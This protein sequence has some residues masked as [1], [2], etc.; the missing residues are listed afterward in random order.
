MQRTMCRVNYCN[1]SLALKAFSVM[2]LVMALAGIAC[3]VTPDPD[4][5]GNNPDKYTPCSG[6]SAPINK[7]CSGELCWWLTDH[8]F[9]GIC[10]GNNGECKRAWYHYHVGKDKAWGIFREHI[11]VCQLDRP[12]TVPGYT[13]VRLSPVKDYPGEPW[14]FLG[15]HFAG[16]E[17]YKKKKY[18]L[19]RE[20]GCDC[21]NCKCA[22]IKQQCHITVTDCLCPCDPAYCENGKSPA[23]PFPSRCEIPC[24]QDKCKHWSSTTKQMVRCV[25]PS[26]P[27]D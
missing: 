13:C 26:K 21:P 18:P 12:C 19:Y 1:R 3:G 16:C 8:D 17:C 25:C 22:D 10:H 14:M 5:A 11:S 27:D 24:L 15:C 23:A 9:A 6:Q 20:P 4:S 7:T 2:T